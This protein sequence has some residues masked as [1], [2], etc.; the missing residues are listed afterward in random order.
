MVPL[1]QIALF[2]WNIISVGMLCFTVTYGLP[3]PLFSKCFAEVSVCVGMTHS[4]SPGCLTSW[5]KMVQLYFHTRNN[6]Y[7]RPGFTADGFSFLNE[8]LLQ[9]ASRMLQRGCGCG[10]KIIY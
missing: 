3:T 5:N 6:F 4:F 9:K 10:H 8:D 1:L 7:F 2:C